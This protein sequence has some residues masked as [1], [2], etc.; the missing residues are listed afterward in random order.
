MEP[1]PRMRPRHSW[2][3]RLLFRHRAN[4]GATTATG[5]RTPAFF[6]A[7]F[8]HIEALQTLLAQRADMDARDAK[9][10]SVLET[11]VVY[12]QVRGSI[13]GFGKHRKGVSP[14]SSTGTGLTSLGLG[15]RRYHLMPKFGPAA[16]TRDG[17]TDSPPDASPS[18]SIP[19][20]RFR[21]TS[22][23][24]SGPLF[25]PLPIH[26]PKPSLQRGDRRGSTLGG[27]DAFGG[28]WAASRAR[29]ACVVLC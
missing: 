3:L 23:R 27:Q 14:T 11:A 18:R 24:I 5:R 13:G 10:T 4:V 7:S 9:A 15:R 29:A 21:A 12:G 28:G 19:M 17:C 16:S 20:H 6:A 26:I 8:G 22:L 2:A 1:T 25:D